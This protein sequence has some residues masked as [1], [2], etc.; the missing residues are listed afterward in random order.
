[1]EFYLKHPGNLLLRILFFSIINLFGF[2]LRTVQ[3][4]Q[5]GD[6]YFINLENDQ[7]NWFPADMIDKSRLDFKSIECD[8]IRVKPLNPKPYPSIEND[9]VKKWFM[10][11]VK[12]LS[13]GL[14]SSLGTKKVNIQ[15]IGQLKIKPKSI[16]TELFYMNFGEGFENSKY[17]ILGLNYSKSNKISSLIIFSELR[18]L[19]GF[20]DLNYSVLTA[21]GIIR[22]IAAPPADIVPLTEMKADRLKKIKINESG[23]VKVRLF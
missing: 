18:C 21:D 3:A 22:I 5:N 15:Y 16:R 4:Q 7:L 8:T 12:I 6:S 19:L 11:K 20:S 14:P 23:K 1:M 17:M 13:N 10:D 2:H 9:L